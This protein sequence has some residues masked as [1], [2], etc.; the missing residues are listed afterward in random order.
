MNYKMYGSGCME[1]LKKIPTSLPDI[2]IIEPTVFSDSRGFF[3]ESYNRRDMELIG[4]R[5]NFVQDN[6][7]CS[8]KG[9]VRGLHF[10]IRHPQ[11]KLVRV[12]RGSIY[13]VVV[14]I[15]KG[16]PT[17]GKAIGFEISAQNFRMLW[18]PVGFAHGFLSL[19]DHTDVLYK[20]TDFYNPEYDAGIRWN[21][22]DLAINW[23]LAQYGISSAIISEKDAKLP[24]LHEFE[25]P[26]EC[27]DITS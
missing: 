1:K 24:L 14:D 23:P 15:R 12:L 4:I 13:D 10:Q 20:T 18:I 19:E 6:Q 5:D 21:D 27:G 25:S 7:S 3:Y 8:A 17:F 22:P 11:G 16:S 26:F 2:F 9:V